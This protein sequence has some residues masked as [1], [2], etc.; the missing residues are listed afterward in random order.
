MKILSFLLIAVIVVV[1]PGLFDRVEAQTTVAPIDSAKLAEWN[2]LAVASGMHAGHT[3]LKGRV[4]K[5]EGRVSKLE[6]DPGRKALAETVAQ[7]A[8]SRGMKN[9]LEAGRTFMS[10]LIEGARSGYKAVDSLR[11]LKADVDSL[12]ARLVVMEF[13][14]AQT[15]S[16]IATLFGNQAELSD[17]VKEVA[18]SAKYRKLSGEE[19]RALR[20]KAQKLAARLLNASIYVP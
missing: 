8:T 10:E 4:T 11:V 14:Q 13:R 19:E 15:D 5:V 9:G 20:E 6:N 16:L 2:G 7:F 3:R 18:V 1:S 12:A 17:V